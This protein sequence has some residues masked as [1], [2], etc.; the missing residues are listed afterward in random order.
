MRRSTLT[1]G[2]ALVFG[3]VLGVTAAGLV[4][5]MQQGKVSVAEL[6][7]ADLVT[8]DGKEASMFMAELAPGAN[9]G[10][11]YHPGDAFAYILEGTML[12]E[13]AGKPSVTL[14][15]GQS[16]SLP[17]R[18]VHDDKNASQTAP[19]KFLVFHVAKKGEPLAVP[20]Q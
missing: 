5:A 20:V 11:H 19:L 9:M 3:M 17:P 15:V 8:S 10:K 2:A 12:L 16:G 1:V 14:T 18:T 13:I 6:Y 7:K 4:N